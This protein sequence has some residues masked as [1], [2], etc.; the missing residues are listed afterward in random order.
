M[1]WWVLS[2]CLV[3]I[4]VALMQWPRALAAYDADLVQGTFE[5]MGPGHHVMGALAMIGGLYLLHSFRT[6]RWWVAWPL[7]LMLFSLVVMSDSKQVILA[8]FVAYALLRGRT[9]R[10]P[11]A[12]VGLSGRLLLG[13]AVIYVVLTYAGKAGYFTSITLVLQ[14]FLNKLAVFPLLAN[15]FDS[16]AQWLFGLGPGHGVSRMGGWLIDHYWSVLEPLG[17]T[18]TGIGA[19]AWKA[20]LPYSARSSVFALLYSWAGVFGEVGL[21]G[22]ALYAALY[23]Y[24]YRRLCVDDLSR[25]ILLS[26]AV[27]GFL[28]EWLEEPNFML[29]AFAVI[30]QKWLVRA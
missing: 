3:Q 25:L 17:G 26:V 27:L 14:G 15:H 29:F 22:F 2:L 23:W 1:G 24:T 16:L 11:A 12:A 4:P 13:V 19:E 7:A 28:F 8:F 21:A 9:V 30:A 20:S 6:V 18:R 10:T 5:G